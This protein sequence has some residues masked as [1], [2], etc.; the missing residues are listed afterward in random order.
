MNNERSA[1]YYGDENFRIAQAMSRLCNGRVPS[2]EDARRYA[3]EQTPVDARDRLQRRLPLQV[4]RRSVGSRL[5]GQRPMARRVP[6]LTSEDTTMALK[7]VPASEP[8][9]VN[10]ITMALYGDPGSGKTTLAFTADKPLLFDFDSGA[11]RA[12]NRK[13]VVRVSSWRD[14]DGLTVDDLAPFN[15]IIIDTAGRM[16]DALAA[17]IIANDAKLGKGGV[18]SQ[19]G[20]GRLKAR[21]IGWLKLL[22]QSGKDV[23]LVAH[24]TEKM[25]GETVNARL[26][27]QGGSKDEIY[28]SV[29][30]MGRVFIRSGKRVLCFDPTESAFGKNPGQFEVLD[31]PSPATDPHFLAGVI[32]QT[33][34]ALN[35]QTEDMRK[36]AEELESWREAIEL[37][38]SADDFNGKLAA[39]KQ[40]SKPI[41]KLYA[42]AA[43]KHGLAFDAK[44]KQYAAKQDEAA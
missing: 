40:Q 28:K 17:D 1:S 29:D 14:V 2:F 25:D 3:M 38:E 10:R 20:W 39:I 26:D 16:L 31:I 22:N 21:F 7:I 12:M 24:G 41:Q 37:L 36:A 11:H 23:V 4:R 18:L 34:D 30:A 44:A 19:Q 5:E 42:D 35:A 27:V 13:D 8:I 9:P 15:T 6:R 43:T 32:Q 33:K